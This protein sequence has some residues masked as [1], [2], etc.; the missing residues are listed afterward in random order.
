MPSQPNTLAVANAIVSYATALTYSGGASVYNAVGLSEIKD[1]T[2]VV[3]G[4]GACLEVYAN[5]DDSQRH[6][7]GGKIWDEQSWFLLSLVNMDNAASAE[8]L[9]Y[10]VRDALVQPFQQH[11]TLGNAGS[12]FHAQIKPNSGRFLRAQRNGQWLR[13][14]LLEILTKSEWFVPTPPGIIS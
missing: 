3:A 8:A 10:N 5:T 1:V 7:F 2:D 4:G 14:H 13:G 6:A 9:I 12:V 11:A